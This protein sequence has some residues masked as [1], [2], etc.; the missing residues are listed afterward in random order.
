MVL[1]STIPNRTSLSAK[2]TPYIYFFCTYTQTFFSDVRYFHC[3]EE[4]KVPFEECPIEPQF[5][6]EDHAWIDSYCQIQESDTLQKYQDFYF[7]SYPGICKF[8]SFFYNV[9]LN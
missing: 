8:E 9:E 2:G 7:G 6:I 4:L 3:T 5:N 1:R